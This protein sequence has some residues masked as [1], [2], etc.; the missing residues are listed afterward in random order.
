VFIENVAGGDTITDFAHGA[1]GDVL[2]LSG[3][4]TLDSAATQTQIATSGS[5]TFNTVAAGTTGAV[6]F[7]D[8]EI[9]ILTGDTAS[10]GT[11][12]LVAA[13]LGASKAFE[14]VTSADN[15]IIIVTNSD[16]GNAQV[17][18]AV[19][20]GNTTL[21]ASEL[22]LLAELTGVSAADATLLTADNFGL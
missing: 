2:D 17:Y 3:V 9:V 18:E 20:T 5:G 21:A 19:D 11:A 13:E 8:N 6:V 1:T 12:T 4:L 16:T 15:I 7:D 10:V 22:T 14:A